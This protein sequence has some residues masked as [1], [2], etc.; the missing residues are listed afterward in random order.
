VY[1]AP[2]SPQPIGGVIDNTI[3]LF[4]ASF[5]YCWPAAL[6]YSLVAI[7]ITIWLQPE[8]T[9]P[10]NPTVTEA[11][12]RF[13]RPAVMGGNLLLLLIS[14]VINLMMTATIID[15]AYNRGSRNALGRFASTL[16][17]LPGGIG[18]GLMVGLGVAVFAMIISLTGPL[19][20]LMAVVCMVLVVYCVVRWLLWTAAYTDRREGAFV[21]MGTSWRLVGG[22]WW[23]TMAVMSV[24]GIVVFVLLLVL[25]LVVS[26]SAAS[27][28][29]DQGS[30]LILSAVV[31]GALQVL[32]LPAFCVAAVAIYQDLRLRKGGDDL[33]ARLG[34]LGGS[35]A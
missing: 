20:P 34:G 24:V 6:L 28:G 32:Y 21:A 3:A 29:M 18:V 15:I 25:S 35:Q 22:N 17:L 4:K 19:A 1:A 14:L 16:L 27:A 11:L 13:S 12:S 30:Q 10:E 23:R 8:L 9:L 2:Q 26:L 31:E 7:G 5:R 33:E